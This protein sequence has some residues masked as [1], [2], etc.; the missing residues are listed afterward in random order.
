MPYANYC[1]K[2]KTETPPGESCPYCG[3]KLTKTGQRLSFGVTRTPLTDWFCWNEYLRLG[4]PVIVTI[5]LISVITELISGGIPALSRLFAGGFTLSI[6][7]MVAGLL[8]LIFLLLFLQGP[9]KVHYILTK[10]CVRALTYLE[11]EA[12]LPMYARFVT[13]QQAQALETTDDVLPGY[14]LIRQAEL[15]WNSLSRVRLW[16]EGGVMLFYRPGWWQALS[17]NVPMEEWEE[18]EAFVRSKLKRQK[19]KVLPE[20]RKKKRRKKAS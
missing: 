5:F 7:M 10:D 15:P 6:L 9:E 12:V 3:G 8:L 4:L 2:C 18:A 20:E 14:R 13:T 11:P 1:R 19:A 17:V 16:R